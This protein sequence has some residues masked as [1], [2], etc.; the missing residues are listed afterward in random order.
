MGGRVERIVAVS[1]MVL[2]RTDER[3]LIHLA[4]IDES[5]FLEVCPALPGC[6]QINGETAPLAVERVLRERFPSFVDE[7]SIGPTQVLAN[8]MPAM[9]MVRSTFYRT[10]QYVFVSEVGDEGLD[11]RAFDE[12]GEHSWAVTD[13]RAVQVRLF[14][15]DGRGS[16]IRISMRKSDAAKSMKEETWKKGRNKGRRRSTSYQSKN[17]DELTAICEAEAF[18]GEDGDVY[19]WLTGK[20]FDT[21]QEGVDHR[22]I[23][24][25]IASLESGYDRLRSL[26]SS[27]TTRSL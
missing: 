11:S 4:R 25:W 3:F 1:A 2:L 27:I 14:G 19:V 16:T 21:L 24:D 22:I 9:Y 6:T 8:G 15:V 18:K 7:V 23:T 12:S 5:G 20:D 13:Q 17:E 10:L 26:A